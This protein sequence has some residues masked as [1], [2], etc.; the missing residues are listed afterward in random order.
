[1][2]NIITANMLEELGNNIRVAFEFLHPNGLTIEELAELANDC[3]YYRG[4]YKYV[5]RVCT[6]EYG[7]D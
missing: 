3:A 4:I 6:N 2:N 7:M 5:R 1:M